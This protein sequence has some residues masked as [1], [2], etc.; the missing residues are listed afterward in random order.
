MLCANPDASAPRMVF[1]RAIPLTKNIPTV[2]IVEARK[3]SI[4]IYPCQV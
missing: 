3:G 1:R 2:A 4:E